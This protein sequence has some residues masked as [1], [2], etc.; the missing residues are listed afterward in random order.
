MLTMTGGKLK[1]PVKV[2]IA[3]VMSAPRIGFVNNLTIAAKV[4][5][6]LGIEVDIGYGVYWSQALTRMLE[7]QIAKG[8]DW[9]V[10]LDYDSF[11]VREHF[12][13]LCRLMAEY[14]EADAI[15][16]VQIKREGDSILASVNDDKSRQYDAATELIEVDTGHLGLTILRASAFAKLKKPWFL[17]VPDGKGEWGEGHIDDDTYFWNNWR[18][19][20]LTLFIAPKILIGHLQLMI[21]WPGRPETDSIP[22]HQ[23]LNDCDAN[24]IPEWCKLTAGMK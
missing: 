5:A 14:P 23:Y 13:G 17:P 22:Y 1:Q 18:G 21:T 4:L 19:C 11:Y 15:M 9:L 24:G 10:V 20:G 2:K 16:P 7:Q 6:P 3:A 12:L 8:Y